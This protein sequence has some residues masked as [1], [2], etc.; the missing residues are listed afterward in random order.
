M[1]RPSPY[2]V[3]G[4]WVYYFTDNSMVYHRVRRGRST[5]PGLLKLLLHIKSLEIYLQCRLEL[6]H[7]P[8]TVMTT[9]G[10]DDQSR[11]VGVY[12]LNQG[13]V[14]PT[15]SIFRPDRYTDVLVD[16]AVS[17]VCTNVLLLE[18]NVETDLSG[19][20]AS[21]LLRRLTLGL[22]N[23]IFARHAITRVLTAWVE[24]PLDNQHLFFIPHI[25]QR[26]YGR[27]KKNIFLVEQCHYLPPMCGVQPNTVP[28]LLFH[29]PL[30]NMTLKSKYQDLDQSTL[31]Q[32]PQWVRAQAECVREV[33]PDDLTLDWWSTLVYFT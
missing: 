7:V 33:S 4:R 22:V 18:W 10:M 3:R 12:N 25:I 21:N 6:I 9:Q 27:V 28:F 17:R 31:I 8:G 29:L 20:A 30:F 24:S 14:T 26:D 5:Y 13:A 16:W 32:P 19:W 11:G 23:P 1:K 15:M 2:R